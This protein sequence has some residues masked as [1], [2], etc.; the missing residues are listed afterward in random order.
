V[1]HRKFINN[2]SEIRKWVGKGF[3]SLMDQGL[4]ATSN[5]ILNIFLARWLIPSEYGAF[6]I[7]Y[8]V[9]LLF[10]TFHTALLNE[11]MLVFGSGKY[12]DRIGVYFHAILS[13]HWVF[14]I[15]IGIIFLLVST[16]LKAFTSSLLVPAFF[17]L[18]FSSPLILYQCLLRRACYIKMQPKFAASSG[19]LYMVIILF[20]TFGLHRVDWLGISTSFFLMAFGNLISGWWLCNKLNIR[21]LKIYEKDCINEA[22]NDHW[23][24]GKWALGSGAL[25][26]IPNNAFILILPIYWGLDASAA[27]RAQLNFI[28]PILHAATALGAILLPVLAEK[29]QTADF[30]LLVKRVSIVSVLVTAIYWVFLGFLGESIIY[31]FYSGKY[32]EYSDL[33]WVTGLVPVL[34]VL[35][36]IL[37]VALQALEIPKKIMQAYLASST[38][39]LT[40]GMLSVIFLGVKGAV[41]GWLIASIV[42]GSIMTMMLKQHLRNS[43]YRVYSS[44]RYVF[45]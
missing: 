35:I 4:F 25:A 24:Y 13:G 26:W 27:Y 16:T 9:F 43:A 11:P 14:S 30:K 32:S 21:R 44:G 42:I 36:A 18:A 1:I 40:F 6:G 39:T 7:A 29:K 19:A 41:I 23:R 45:K 20:G 31:A 2:R 12:K 38:I 22:I 17:G 15:C 5:F 37:A 33:L 10:A 8:T 28:L 3:W 34:S